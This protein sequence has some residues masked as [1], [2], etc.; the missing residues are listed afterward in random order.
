MLTKHP[1]TQVEAFQALYRNYIDDGDT[2]GLYR[3]LMQLAELLPEDRR[4]Q[5]NL[6]QLRLLLSADI[7]Q[8]EKLSAD[9]YSKEPSNPF[10]AS[11]YA[12]ALYS[13]GDT[14]GALEIMNGLRESQLRDPSL[15]TYYGIILA[16]AGENEKARKYLDLAASGKL[17]PEERA[18]ITRA[19]ESLK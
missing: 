9:L 15:A 4:I 1:E 19:E 2:P 5:N 18:L 11:T 13:V 17:L 6:A 12:F 3:V 16:A 7:A 14:D 10:Y 8:A